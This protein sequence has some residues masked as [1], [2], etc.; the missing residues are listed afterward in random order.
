MHFHSTYY[1][2]L[3]FGDGHHFCV[4][5]CS[6]KFHRVDYNMLLLNYIIKEFK[7]KKAVKLLSSI[8]FTIVNRRETEC[9]NIAKLNKTCKQMARGGVLP[10]A[11]RQRAL[12]Q[13]GG[14]VLGPRRLRRQQRRDCVQRL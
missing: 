5:L 4:N 1:V 2:I 8:C 9:H 12:P 11:V 7:K 14:G 10:A 6:F 13:H 3:H